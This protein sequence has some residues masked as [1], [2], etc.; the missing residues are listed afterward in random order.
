ML[1]NLTEWHSVDVQYGIR[2]GMRHASCDVLAQLNF[3][4]AQ[5]M[6]GR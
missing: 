5:L 1:G 4:S 6:A 2:H 3:F